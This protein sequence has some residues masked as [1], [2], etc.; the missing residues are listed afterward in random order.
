MMKMTRRH[1]LGS[2]LTAV[3][4]AASSKS[5]A[6]VA[7]RTPCVGTGEIGPQLKLGCAAYSLR[8]YLPQGGKPGKMSLLD[9]LELAAAWNLDGVELTSYY[10]TS[11]APQAL[12]ELKAKAF[13][14]G[15]DISGTSVG[16]DFCLPAGDERSKQTDLTKRWVDH[17]V[18]LGAPCVR[19]FAG[20]KRPGADRKSDF[21]S[22]VECLK[23]CCDYAGT[24]GVFLAL[25]NHGYLTETGPEVLA[26]LEAV[27]N[28]WLGLNLDTGNFISDPYK[29]MELVAPKTITTHTKSEVRTA[30]GSGSEPADFPRIMN[31]LRAANYRGYISLEYEAK[32]DAMTAVPKTLASLREAMK[33]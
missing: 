15:L 2:G 19:V 25:E 7:P 27:N 18:E 3:A 33:A 10:F 1:L 23:P 28:E 17:S 20:H 24:H 16:N 9:W 22:V 29:N 5:E 31:I 21:A 12:C 8:D 14:L 30:D 4:V 6:A 32:E 11:E 26:I 13:K